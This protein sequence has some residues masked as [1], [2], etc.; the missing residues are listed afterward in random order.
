MGLITVDFFLLLTIVL[1][2]FVLSCF[3]WTWPHT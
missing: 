2:F 1:F 3:S